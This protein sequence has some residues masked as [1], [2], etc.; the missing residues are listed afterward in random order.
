MK[1]Q[2]VGGMRINQIQPRMAQKEKPN[3]TEANFA[4]AKEAKA[5]REQIEKIYNLTEEVW[6]TYNAQPNG[7]TKD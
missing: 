7:I 5:T 6:N 3:L 1:G 2:I 4:K